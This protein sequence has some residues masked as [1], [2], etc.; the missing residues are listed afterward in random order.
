MRLAVKLGLLLSGGV[1][2]F[3]PITLV[4]YLNGQISQ[5]GYASLILSIWF[6]SGLLLSVLGMVGL[7][8]GKTFEQVKQRPLYVVDST[9]DGQGLREI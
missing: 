4:R 9:A 6:F 8:V 7:Y 2:L 5:P 3:V 1:F